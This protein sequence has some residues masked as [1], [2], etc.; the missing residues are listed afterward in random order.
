MVPE[1]DVEL[2]LKRFAA[3]FAASAIANKLELDTSNATVADTV[4]SLAAGLE[5]FLTD[6]D[7]ARRAAVASK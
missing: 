7:R 2:V 4:R 3:A 5:P 6:R 1:A